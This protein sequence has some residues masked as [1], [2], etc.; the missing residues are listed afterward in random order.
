MVAPLEI[1]M[2]DSHITTI[3]LSTY[4]STPKVDYNLFNQNQRTKI[5]NGVNAIINYFSRPII[6]DD[7]TNHNDRDVWLQQQ[8]TSVALYVRQNKLRN[9]SLNPL[10]YVSLLALF[11][12][13]PKKEEI[14]QLSERI[15]QQ[16]QDTS[17]DVPNINDKIKKIKNLEQSLYSFLELISVK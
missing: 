11:Y 5:E 9:N 6:I 14:N 17:L 13:G 1:L 2:L 7:F 12:Q 3:T 4:V 8:T 16:V 15:E 10:N